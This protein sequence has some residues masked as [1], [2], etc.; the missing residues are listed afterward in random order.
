MSANNGTSHTVKL[1]NIEHLCQLFSGKQEWD[2][3]K[4][5]AKSEMDR[6]PFRM[7][8][9]ERTAMEDGNKTNNQVKAECGL[10]VFNN[11]VKVGRAFD[12][13]M[14]LWDDLE[15]DKDLSYIDDEDASELRTWFEEHRAWHEKNVPKRVLEHLTKAYALYR[16]TG[17][18][19]MPEQASVVMIA[20]SIWDG[21]S[22][23]E[24]LDEA[25]GVLQPK[26]SVEQGLYQG[27]IEQAMDVVR[28]AKEALE[29]VNKDWANALDWV[30]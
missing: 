4:G 30:E 28:L 9:Q 5:A 1:A 14:D 16:L 18:M 7:T 20:H 21:S 3:A 25:E 23:N 29:L 17:T 6:A 8:E 15:N 22:W 13:G 2:N 11:M 19:S 10:R 24:R 27:Y 12:P 26:P